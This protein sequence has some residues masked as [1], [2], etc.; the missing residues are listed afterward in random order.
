LD[1]ATVMMYDFYEIPLKLKHAYH[2]NPLF[3]LKEVN[4]NQECLD[5]SVKYWLKSGFPRT[6]LVLGVDL[7]ARTYTMFGGGKR[8]LKLGSTVNREGLQGSYTR[9]P[10]ILSYYEVCN[11][12]LNDDDDD[13]DSEQTWTSNWLADEKVPYVYNQKLD[14]MIFYEDV[15]SVETTSV[16]LK[17]KNLA[18]IGLFSLDLD[19]STGLFC[20]EGPYPLVNRAKD[21]LTSRNYL[22]IF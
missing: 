15:E 17:R 9:I 11:R 18:G 12:V 20:M 16:D 5:T 4:K 13:N 10:G 7:Y 19:D 1:F 6:K 3:D 14:Q 21:V 2:H 8:S 22:K